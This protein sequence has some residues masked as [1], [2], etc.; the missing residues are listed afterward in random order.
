[1]GNL[2]SSGMGSITRQQLLA[3]T[4]DNREFTNKIFGAMISKLTPA[5]ILELSD[6]SKCSK[7]I[8][9]MA[10]SFDKIFDDLKIR[11]ERDSKSGLVYYKKVDDLVNPKGAAATEKLLLCREIAYFNIR[12]F[13]IFGALALSIIDDNAAGAIL[14][15]YSDAMRREMYSLEHRDPEVARD[16]WGRPRTRPGSKPV[17]I[18]GGVEDGAFPPRWPEFKNLKN[19]LDP[20]GSILADGVTLNNVLVFSGSEIYLY[21]ESRDGINTPFLYYNKDGNSYYCK[22]LLQTPRVENRDRYRYLGFREPELDLDSAKLRVSLS[23]FYYYNTSL[24]ETAYRRINSTL[25]TA[26]KTFDIQSTDNKASWYT[27]NERQ[28]F[29][30]ALRYN[31]VNTIKEI[32]K[33]DEEGKAVFTSEPERVSYGGPIGPGRGVSESGSSDDVLRTKY[34]ID[35]IQGIAKGDKVSFCVGR[36][37]QLIDAR[38]S[39]SPRP[40]SVTSSVCKSK[41]ESLPTSV[42]SSKLTEVP[43]LKSLDQLYYKPVASSSSKSVYTPDESYVE[44]LTKM[45]DAFNKGGAA[46]PKSLDAVGVRAS[47]CGR[48][49]INKYLYINDPKKIKEIMGYVNGL[50]GIQLNH[51]KKVIEFFRTKLFLIQKTSRGITIDIHP[52]LLTGDLNELEKVSKDARKL[53]VDYYLGCENKYKEGL[54][55]VLTESST[56][57]I[58]PERR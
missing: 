51:T 11:P 18:G 3:S 48:E 32:V 6:S 35:T 52:S 53:L 33:R 55:A 58:T 46:N 15:S 26:S 43:G 14:G 25:K 23:T 2:V 47:D 12:L 57:K 41:L 29:V 40:S 16:F 27:V 1:M 50:F 8:F 30:T 13:Q 37:L 7:Y 22:I 44:F 38:S 54:K 28:D 4:K 56:Y 49:A 45:K 39:F 24:S 31:L 19:I 10:Q 20:A 9:L 21:F 36:A 5:D 42:P 34:I 17:M